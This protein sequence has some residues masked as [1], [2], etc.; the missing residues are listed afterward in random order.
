M[1]F[2]LQKLLSQNVQKKLRHKV[3]KN[4]DILSYIWVGKGYISITATKEITK[5]MIN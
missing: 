3:L 5:E 1:S 2:T 4:I